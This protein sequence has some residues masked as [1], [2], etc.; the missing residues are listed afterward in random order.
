VAAT[1]TDVATESARNDFTWR[2]LTVD[3][4]LTADFNSGSPIA[5]KTARRFPGN[6]AKCRQIVR[7]EGS[8]ESQGDFKALQ[9]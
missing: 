1:K 2:D 6:Y 9:L 7:G 5:G 8:V 4:S 3:P